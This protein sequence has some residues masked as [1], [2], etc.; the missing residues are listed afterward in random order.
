MSNHHAF[1][2]FTALGVA[3][4]LLSPRAGHAGGARSSDLSLDAPGDQATVVRVRTPGKS[5][6]TFR[7][8][9]EA[10]AEGMVL[11]FEVTSIGRAGAVKR[12]RCVAV[13]DVSECLGQPVRVAY[14]PS[15]DAIVLHAQVAPGSDPGPAFALR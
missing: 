1:R 15:D 13:D 8:Q 7:A 10:I 2:L 5:A 11:V 6:V 9:S 3:A 14:L 4:A 12:W